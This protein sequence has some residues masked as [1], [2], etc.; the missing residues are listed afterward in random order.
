MAI[1]GMYRVQNP[2]QRAL[3]I[4]GGPRPEGGQGPAAPS[5]GTP[6]RGVGGAGNTY[7]P[8]GGPTFRDHYPDE[9]EKLFDTYTKHMQGVLEE[10]YRQ[11]YM[12][13]EYLPDTPENMAQTEMA[14]REGGFQ[15]PVW[16]KFAHILMK[17][18]AQRGEDPNL[19]GANSG[20]TPDGDDTPPAK[21]E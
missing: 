15:N 5:G 6:A 21:E 20:S 19:L 1:G 17:K 11:A 12:D 4:E 8:Q 18:R 10:N 7:G 2:A 16:R 14:R 13:G 3:G 9:Y